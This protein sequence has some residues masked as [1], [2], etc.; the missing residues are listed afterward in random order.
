M[1]FIFDSITVPRLDSDPFIKKN[2]ER[3][4]PRNLVVCENKKSFLNSLNLELHY[5][6]SDSSKHGIN[7][8]ARMFQDLLYISYLSCVVP[9]EQ[10]KISSFDFLKE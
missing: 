8:E 7:R 2:W 9:W 1:E 10:D 5:G 4:G 6:D 3:W